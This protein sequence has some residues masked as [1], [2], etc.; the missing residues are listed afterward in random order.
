MKKGVD[1]LT[2]HTKERFDR[3]SYKTSL[4]LESLLLDSLMKEATELEGDISFVKEIYGDDVDTSRLASQLEL[5]KT[6]SSDRNLSC[7]LGLQELAKSFQ[8]ARG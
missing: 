5:F 8:L 1:L 6:M 2:T 4:R 3:P 7:F